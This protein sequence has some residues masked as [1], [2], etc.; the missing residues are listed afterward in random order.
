MTLLTKWMWQCGTALS[1]FP[2]SR[3]SAEDSQHKGMNSYAGLP[4]EDMMNREMMDND[5]GPKHRV[6]YKDFSVLKNIHS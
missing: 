1:G 6:W 2:Y 5:M 4:R 3:T